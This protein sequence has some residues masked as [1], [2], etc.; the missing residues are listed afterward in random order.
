M[1][2]PC[3]QLEELLAAGMDEIF[4]H[5]AGTYALTLLPTPILTGV[6]RAMQLLA[7]ETDPRCCACS[8]ALL[9]QR[10]ILEPYPAG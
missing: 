7:R 4:A 9:R 8:P 2:R 6:L 10:P 5:R 3:L 1:G